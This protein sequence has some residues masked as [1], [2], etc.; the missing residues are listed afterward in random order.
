MGLEGVFQG[1][2]G[3]QGWDS[4]PPAGQG[5]DAALGARLGGPATW[6][7]GQVS[8]RQE[9]LEAGKFGELGG[10]PD[11]AVGTARWPQEG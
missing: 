5:R 6:G 4:G 9:H 10:S 3:T 2:R 7:V 11:K 1:L 8:E